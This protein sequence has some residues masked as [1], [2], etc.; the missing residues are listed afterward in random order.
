MIAE[1]IRMYTF[2]AAEAAKKD[3]GAICPSGAAALLTL[4]GEVAA[5]LAECNQNF[6]E[7]KHQIMQ[8]YV[9][10]RPR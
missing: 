6:C 8:G 4:L 7:L 5:Q 9:N 10:V 3:E 2:Q 1:E